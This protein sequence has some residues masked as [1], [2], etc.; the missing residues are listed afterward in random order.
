MES[1]PE[2]VVLSHGRARWWTP[3]PGR[4][5]TR[6][7]TQDP[8]VGPPPP[9]PPP[10]PPHHYPL[11]PARPTWGR[12]AVLFAAALCLAIAGVVGYTM[13]K[14]NDTVVQQPTDFS[15]PSG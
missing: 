13:G 1:A 9:P 3:S 6:M 8:H 2:Q 7:M 5:A 12:S 15:T 4:G 11:P 14:G 10:P